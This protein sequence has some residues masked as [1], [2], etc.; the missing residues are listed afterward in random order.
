M[1]YDEHFVLYRLSYILCRFL[2]YMV[3]IDVDRGQIL[4]CWCWVSP[5]WA[6][7]WLQARFCCVTLN[8]GSGS[9]EARVNPWL[10][11]I[12]NI[13]NKDNLWI[14]N[15]TEQHENYFLKKTKE[16]HQGQC[17]YLNYLGVPLVVFERAP[18]CERLWQREKSPTSCGLLGHVIAQGHAFIS[19]SWS[20]R[21]VYETSLKTV[22]AR[23][24]SYKLNMPKNELNI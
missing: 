22:G 1:A 8:F 10:L 24:V 6:M 9:L 21:H 12:H 18:L 5:V 3:Y 7:G 11:E 23:I 15:I 14:F 2:L 19:C 16:K 4:K 20:K 13:T 17:Y